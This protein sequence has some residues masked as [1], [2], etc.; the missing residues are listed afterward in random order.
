MKK[1]TLVYLYLFG[2][3]V[4]VTWQPPHMPWPWKMAIDVADTPPVNDDQ[5]DHN[6][7]GLTLVNAG[8]VSPE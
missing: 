2:W 7:Q 3:L 8:Y 5:G 6:E 1:L 4:P